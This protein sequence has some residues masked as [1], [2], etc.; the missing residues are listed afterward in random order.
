MK[1]KLGLNTMK[2]LNL[3]VLLFSLVKSEELTCL[4]NCEEIHAQPHGLI[5]TKSCA[6]ISSDICQVQL[7]T[8]YQGETFPKYFN[9]TFGLVSSDDNE[10]NSIKIHQLVNFTRFHFILNANL[11]ETI[12]IAEIYCT[13]SNSC[14]LDAI[15]PLIKKYSQQINPFYRIQSL[16]HSKI[17]PTDLFCFDSN[18]QSCSSFKNPVCIWNSV[19]DIRKCSSNF[20]V[21]VHYVLTFSFPHETTFERSQELIQC[22]RNYCATEENLIQLE[23]IVKQSLSDRFQIQNLAHKQTNSYVFVYSTLFF[24]FL[25]YTKH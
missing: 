24:G 6:R 10:L 4:S 16:I 9:Y 13:D 12:L 20:D 3:F 23:T 18:D 25:Y 1:K 11:E 17:S 19:N 14:Q 21:H 15:K 22:N 8:Y 7:I 5:Q 2:K